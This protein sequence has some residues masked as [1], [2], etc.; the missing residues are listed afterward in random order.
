MR[1]PG[2]WGRTPLTLPAASPEQVG[3]PPCVI[4]LVRAA[5][6]IGSLREFAA[7]MRAHPP[8]V[9]HEL[10]LA[11]KGFASKAEAAPYIA[12]A[13]D[14]EP[15][16]EFFPDIGLDL[17][18]LVRA[19]ARLRRNRYCFINSHTR[20]VAADWLAKLDAALALPDVG[21]VGAT[22]SWLSPHSWLTYSMGLPSFYANVLP[23]I[24]EARKLLLEIDLEQLRI[25]RRSK[26]N[27]LRTR[28]RLLLQLPEELL[29]F[30]P[31]PTPHL[32]NTML[33]FC[34]GT[35]RSLR[36]FAVRSKF[37]TY[38]L[39]SGSL[40]M[41][42]QLARMGLRALVV[43]S[44]GAAY[45][46]AEWYRSGTYWQGRQERLLAIDN[47]TLSYERGDVARRR[48]LSALAWGLHADPVSYP[49]PAS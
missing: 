47:R 8:G 13:A 26:L 29:A 30:Q 44:A 5:N 21:M 9:E 48:V 43:D 33:M 15:T 46:P 17:G 40:N 18:L 31:F 14:L 38:V 1:R 11:M 35:L 39:E 23:P 4:H 49:V 12:E 24:R 42:G 16:I 34:H 25:D 2:D 20:P 27:S 7:A 32:R 10:V 41:V 3:G 19:A 45:E 28:L 37:D 22:G 36:L 6:G